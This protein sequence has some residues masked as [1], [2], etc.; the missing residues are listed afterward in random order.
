[1][2]VAETLV[3]INLRLQY[4]AIICFADT[5]PYITVS[6]QVFVSQ[7]IAMAKTMSYVEKTTSDLI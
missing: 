2:E 7:Q 3:K 6:A 1:M 4:S 5:Y